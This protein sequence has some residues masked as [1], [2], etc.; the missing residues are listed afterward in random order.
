LI[1]VI[2]VLVSLVLLVFK[3]LADSSE[4][5]AFLR[6]SRLLVWFIVPLAALF[7]VDL[8]SKVANTIPDLP[9]L[10]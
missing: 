1:T 7:I 8:I 10:F 9:L 3:L 6:I 5:P 2:A 4:K